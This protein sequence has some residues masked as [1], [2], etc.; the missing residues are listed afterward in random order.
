MLCLKISNS[1]QSMYF[2]F[3]AA[4]MTASNLVVP[5]IL[6]GKNAPT[7]CISSI[8]MTPNQKHIVT[9]CN[10]GHMCVWDVDSDWE[11]S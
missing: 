11:V 8:L 4:D 2:S 6:W 7:H 9:G 10:D 1:I 5:M 3:S